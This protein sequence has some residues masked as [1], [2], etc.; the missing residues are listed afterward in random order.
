MYCFFNVK[1]SVLM[2]LLLTFII[3]ASVTGAADSIK[4]YDYNIHCAGNFHQQSNHYYDHVAARVLAEYSSD[5][6]AIKSANS[7]EQNATALKAEFA[8]RD[9]SANPNDL[10]SDVYIFN[11][12]DANANVQAFVKE[13]PSKIFL[14]FKGSDEG[15]DWFNTDFRSEKAPFIINGK[16]V[17]GIEVHEGFFDQA[18]EFDEMVRSANYGG[19]LT[20]LDFILQ[21]EKDVFIAGHSLGG[22]VGTLYGAMLREYGVP[23]NRLAVYT[24]GSPSVGDNAFTARYEPYYDTGINMFRVR[25]RDDVVPY[26]SY[27]RPDLTKLK[28]CFTK[29]PIFG[30]PV[31]GMLK[32]LAADTM[33]SF[34]VHK[35]SH[36][37]F[38]RLHDVNGSQLSN[39]SEATFDIS[40]VLSLLKDNYEYVADQHSVILYTSNVIKNDRLDLP[41][42]L[43]PPCKRID[44][45]GESLLSR[46]MISV[47]DVD[48]M[49]RSSDFRAIPPTVVSQ[50]IVDGSLKLDLRIPEHPF[51]SDTLETQVGITP[52]TRLF[53]SVEHDNQTLAYPPGLITLSRIDVEP[54]I[55]YHRTGSQ[56]VDIGYRVDNLP[57][58]SIQ[59]GQ[60]LTAT[61]PIRIDASSIAFDKDYRP[62]TLSLPDFAFGDWNPDQFSVRL[63]AGKRFEFCP[64]DPYDGSEG[65]LLNYILRLLPLDG[66]DPIGLTSLAVDDLRQ[67]GQ[68]AVSA[69]GEYR[70]EYLLARVNHPSLG[71]KFVQ[72]SYLLERY[73]QVVGLD[74]ASGGSGPGPELP[75][76]HP[77]NDTGITFCGEA[78]SGNNSP[79]TGN[80]PAGQDAH[81]GRDAA[82]AAGKLTKK[83]G[84]SAGF[85]FT[86]IANNGSEL[87][88]SATLGSGPTDWACTRDNVTGL[89][90]EVKVD[91]ATHRRHKWHGYSWYDQASP[92][93]NPGSVGNT[94]TCGNTLDG[95]PCNTANYVAAIRSDRLCGYSDWRMPT[96]KELLGIIDYD[97]SEG[98]WVP[99]VDT[100]YFPNTPA[101]PYT[102]TE[103]YSPRVWSG[104]IDAYYPSDAWVIMINTG[105][106]ER[107]SRRFSTSVRLVRGGQ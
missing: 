4:D 10:L 49:G 21:S 13:T 55:L 6:Y 75:A 18:K 24:F 68:F 50:R 35:F 80:E 56:T 86:K 62:S 41:V 66:G 74:Q 64:S 1:N 23:K 43:A 76:T 14:I 103:N 73:V 29:D 25:N 8:K 40:Y 101:S 53:V 84:G 87:P 71:E 15:D 38:L 104:S 105:W 52:E 59:D 47:F 2:P 32:C 107:V 33:L 16:K 63:K 79:C 70:L 85:D 28:L 46:A 77:L 69:D 12:S 67:C 99:M 61:L 94:S 57:F 36:I 82:A 3:T 97:R 44:Q 20:I 106:Y 9:P 17:G 51:V 91:D 95:Q 30:G 65:E 78:V 48:R 96:K 92:D 31:A 93:G 26:L 60:T 7:A 89:I 90:W 34:F 81:Y 54:D 39:L 45:S 83:G 102:Y 22:A 27:L 58:I 11:S 5:V 88:A 72:Q 37:G 98:G 19:G 100:D 42:D